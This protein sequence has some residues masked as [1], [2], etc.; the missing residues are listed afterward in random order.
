MHSFILH[1]VGLQVEGFYLMA[2]VRG[3]S[4]LLRMKEVRRGF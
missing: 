3:Q 4:G 2:S 1:G